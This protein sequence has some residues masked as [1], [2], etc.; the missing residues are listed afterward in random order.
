MLAFVLDSVRELLRASRRVTNLLGELPEATRDH[1]QI[2]EAILAREPE[3]AR[4]AMRAH[5]LSATRSGLRA[6]PTRRSRLPIQR[7]ALKG[8]APDR[9]RNGHPTVA[10]RSEEGIELRRWQVYEL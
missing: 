1:R 8:A 7:S 5:L 6:A 4:Q 2:F 10:L 9:L 3:T